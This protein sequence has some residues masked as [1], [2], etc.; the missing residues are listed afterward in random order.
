M[1]EAITPFGFKHHS[2]LYH[3]TVYYRCLIDE[4]IWFIHTKSRVFPLQGENHGNC[5]NVMLP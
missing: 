2:L 4:S 3:K 1:N 5:K